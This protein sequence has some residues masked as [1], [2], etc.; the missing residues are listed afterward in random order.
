MSRHGYSED[1]WDDAESQW[2]S[3]RW[4]G[5]VA[6]A[7][8]GKRGQAFFVALVDALD[9]MPVKRLIVGAL[10]K[11]GEVCA[12]G[13]LGRARGIALAQ[14]EPERTEDGD[15][16]EWDHDALGEA[17]DIARQLV[18]E[19]MYQNDEACVET[20]EQRW[21]RVRGWALKRIRPETL[22]PGDTIEKLRGAK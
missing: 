19:V 11:D 2:A 22:V 4:Q 16:P 6:S 3:I 13:C 18:A 15:E 9:A 10:E 8:R 21:S 7:I 14:L 20:P 17:F 12:F 5:Q 1:G